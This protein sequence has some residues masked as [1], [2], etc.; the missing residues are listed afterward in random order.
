MSA[1]EYEYSS[2]TPQIYTW[3]K[4]VTHAS[5]TKHQKVTGNDRK[6]VIGY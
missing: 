6:G 1:D 3:G 5:T 2:K 4:S